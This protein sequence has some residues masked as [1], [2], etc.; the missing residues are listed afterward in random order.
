MAC[1]TAETRRSSSGGGGNASALDREIVG[2]YLRN[3]DKI[4]IEAARVAADYYGKGSKIRR[5]IEEI[6]P[7]MQTEHMSLTTTRLTQSLFRN[8]LLLAYDSKCC[9]TGLGVEQL[10]VASHIKP[11]KD[12]KTEERISASNGLLLNALHDKAFDRGLIKVD[13]NMELHLSPALKKFGFP[14]DVVEN[15][16]EPYEG[17]RISPPKVL[18]AAPKAAFLDWHREKVFLKS[19]NA[20]RQSRSP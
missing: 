12:A 15:F 8:K 14:K 20:L 2:D 16:F 4:T 3:P 9:I 11:W 13:D 7:P 18:E 19:A 5:E 1:T 17:Q 6:M 10:L